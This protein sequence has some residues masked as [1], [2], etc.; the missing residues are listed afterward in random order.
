MLSFPV[1]FDLHYRPAPYLLFFH[2]LPKIAPVTSVCSEPA[3]EPKEKDTL[4]FG[5]V[6]SA[7]FRQPP[8]LLL[9][10]TEYRSPNTWPAQAALSLLKSILTESSFANSFRMNT[11]AKHPGGA[12]FTTHHLQLTSHDDSFHSLLASARLSSRP[13]TKTGSPLARFSLFAPS[14]LPLLPHSS[15]TLPSLFLHSFSAK[16]F[17]CHS[18]E[19]TRGVAPLPRHQMCK[20]LRFSG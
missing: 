4:A 12:A 11:Y 19:Y 16:S 2:T 5:H 9:R 10:T 17:A 14:L 1:K 18:Y 13:R 6:S 20:C 7:S 15:F 8:A 3:E